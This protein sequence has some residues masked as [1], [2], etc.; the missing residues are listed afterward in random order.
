MPLTATPPKEEIGALRTTETKMKRCD[1][2]EYT[3]ILH[4]VITEAVSTSV[5]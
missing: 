5:T 1:P 2:V 4:A 3:Q